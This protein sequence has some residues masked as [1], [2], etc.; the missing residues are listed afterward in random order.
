MFFNTRFQCFLV[1]V[2]SPLCSPERAWE[3][4]SDPVL[5]DVPKTAEIAKK[6]SKSIAQI[7]LKWQIEKGITVV[8]KSFAASRIQENADVSISSFEIFLCCR[9]FHCFN[10]E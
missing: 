7:C 9:K 10:S 5:P 8:P 3:K 6:Y 1:T 4:P 2:Y